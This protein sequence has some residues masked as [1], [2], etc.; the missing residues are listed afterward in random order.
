[1]RARQ[2]HFNARDFGAVQVLDSRFLSGLNDGDGIGTWTDR[3]R[4]GYDMSQAT[5]GFRPTYKTSI[6]GGQ[7]IARFDGGDSMTSS[8]ETATAYS[9]ICIYKR[10]NSQTN[11]ANNA[12]FSWSIGIIGVSNFSASQRLFQFSYNSSPDEF[13]HF[14]NATTTF[15]ISRNNDFNI[16]SVSIPIATGTGSYTTNGANEQTASVASLSGVTSGTVSSVLGD[17]TFNPGFNLKLIGDF[18]LAVVVKSALDK[19]QV[20]KINHAAA[21]SFKIACS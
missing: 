21:Y 9:A 20:K 13:A 7:P 15:S 17:A 1:M 2:R 5:S 3:S 8:F 11:V 16:H 19:S 10:T 6:Q 12:T 18:A 4:S 14:A